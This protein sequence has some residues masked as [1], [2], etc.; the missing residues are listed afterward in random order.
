MDLSLLDITW[1]KILNGFK[2]PA[3]INLDRRNWA[4]ENLANLWT[5]VTTTAINPVGWT[6]NF[7]TPYTVG[8]DFG[9]A[10]T[11]WIV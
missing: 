7:T 5:E 1:R 11:T 6:T 3:Y 4:T 8:V 2:K 10:A 9:T